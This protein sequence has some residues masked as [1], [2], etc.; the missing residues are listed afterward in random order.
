[1][2]GWELL[3]EETA[4]RIWN[5]NLFKFDHYSP[6]QIFE[7]GQYEKGLGWQPQYWVFFDENRQAQTMFLGLLRSYRFGFGFIQC[8]GGPAGNLTNCDS[9]FHR[10]LVEATNSKRL[11]VRVRWEKQ[12]SENSAALLINNKWSRSPFSMTSGLT[13]ELDISVAESL[14]LAGY[15]SKWRRNLRKALK[16]KLSIAA[17]LEPNP[18]EVR[19]VF[20]EMEVRK[21]LPELFAAEKLRNFFRTAGQSVLFLECRNSKGELLAFR[22]AIVAGNRAC[23]YFAA[24]SKQGR[25]LRVSYLLFAEMV[26]QLKAKGVILYDLGG[27]NPEANPGVY[28]FKKE[29][30]AKEVEFLGEWEWASREWLRLVGNRAIKFRQR[31]KSQKIPIFG[32]RKLQRS[33]DK[34]VFPLNQV[35]IAK[36]NI[37]ES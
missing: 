24:A 35:E 15:S 11:Y 23:E 17:C 31:L 37:A 26:R 12:N 5:E 28:R 3:S 4:A 1:M 2:N 10:I 8:V 36:L 33:E 9:K 16:A 19:A 34:V 13:M 32:G 25:E 22:S 30:G 7:Q 18:D 6:F 21:N 14:I 20:S 27:I 29:T